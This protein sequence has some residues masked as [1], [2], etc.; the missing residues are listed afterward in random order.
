LLKENPKII[1]EEKEYVL[2]Q[3]HARSLEQND[4]MSQHYFHALGD[5]IACAEIQPYI[6]NGIEDDFKSG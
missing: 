2:M 1:I 4:K 5:P 6:G 3:I